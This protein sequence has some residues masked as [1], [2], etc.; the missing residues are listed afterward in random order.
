MK[1]IIFWILSFLLITP[2]FAYEI[3]P[4]WSIDNVLS[5]S[6]IQ[7]NNSVVYVWDLSTIRFKNSQG[8][9]LYLTNLP[10][11]SNNVD[12]WSTIDS[13]NYI[14]SF[15]FSW[16]SNY[17]WGTFNSLL[18]FGVYGVSPSLDYIQLYLQRQN[19][20]DYDWNNFWNT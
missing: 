9:L 1:K 5:L 15:I 3:D 20:W 7:N 11:S 13:E 2:V 4:A 8:S 18:S 16:V 6:N 19:S 10:F 14:S 17:S 12:Y